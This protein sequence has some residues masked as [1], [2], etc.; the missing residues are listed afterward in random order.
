MKK[1]A[2]NKNYKIAGCKDNPEELW[3]DFGGP[4]EIYDLLVERPPR[5]TH[6]R[7]EETLQEKVSRISRELEEIKEVLSR[8]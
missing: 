6:G 3:H 2:A 8:E 1:I 4:D 5:R 7:R